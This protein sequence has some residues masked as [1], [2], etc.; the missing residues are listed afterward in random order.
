M[1]FSLV[2]MLGVTVLLLGMLAASEIGRRIGMREA[3]RD[4]G[5]LARG[6][7]PAQAAL[8]AL[9]GLLLAF[10]FSGAASR[11]E[12]RRH[13]ITEETNAIGTAYLRVDLLPEDA[14]PEIRSLFHRYLDVRVATYRNVSDEKATAAKLAEGGSLQQEIWSKCVEASLRPGTPTQTAMLVV[15]ALNAMIDITATRVMASRN[16]PPPIAYLLLAGLSLVG[17]LFVGY[18]TSTNRRRSWL[19]T[20]LFAVILALTIYVIV[21]LEFPRF[22]LI[23]VDDA[24][25]TFEELRDSMR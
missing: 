5:E 22:G 15:P 2:T 3:A 6:T 24:D 9:L 1:N 14:Q 12:A 16:H 10:T 19:H 25:Q 17:A 20:F 7:G 4:S 11:F 18:G 13:L 23:R 21:D 8:F